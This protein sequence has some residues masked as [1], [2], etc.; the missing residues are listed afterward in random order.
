VRAF[1]ETGTWAGLSRTHLGLNPSGSLVVNLAAG[2]VAI[3]AEDSSERAVVD[4][5]TS[6]VRQDG[7]LVHSL[8]HQHYGGDY[9]LHTLVDAVRDAA[10]PRPLAWLESHFFQ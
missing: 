4:L 7:E 9:W 1:Q 3:R 5:Q 10:G 6:T 8:S 2:K